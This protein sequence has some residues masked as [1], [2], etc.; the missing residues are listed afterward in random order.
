MAAVRQGFNPF[1]VGI[2]PYWVDRRPKRIFMR[3]RGR[4]DD[5]RHLRPELD[6]F[7]LFQRAQDAV[8]FGPV[9]VTLLAEL[10][11]RIVFPHPGD[12]FLLRR[13]D[14]HEPDNFVGIHRGEQAIVDAAERLADEYVRR[15]EAGVVQ[16][17]V[18]FADDLLAGESL[19]GVSVNRSGR[20]R[21]PA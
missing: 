2:A 4:Y 8:G 9:F 1:D 3:L 10:L 7:Q 19:F 5:G 12:E 15:L 20:R 14:E 11:F 18:K 6:C 13:I 16:G 21:R 17:R